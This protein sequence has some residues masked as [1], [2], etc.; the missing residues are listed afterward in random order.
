MK[1][2]ILD[3]GTFGPGIDINIYRNLGEL[4][5]Y[6]TTDPSEIN[7]RIKYSDVVIV[8]KVKLNESNLYGCDT[9]KLICVMATGYDNIDVDFC[10]SKGIAV[11]NVVGY[12]TQSVAQLTIAMALHLITHIPEYTLSVKSGRY[13]RGTNANILSPVYHE[14]YG[15]TW[16]IVGY[17]N[18][19]RQV[20]SVARAM[21]CKI[22]VNKRE[23]VL[24]VDC[25]DIDTLCEQSDIISI[26][27]PLNNSTRNL[28][29]AERVAKMK[30]TAIV[31]N[32]ARGAVVDEYAL[33]KA[34][35]EGKLGGIGIDV[36]TQEPFDIQHPYNSLSAYDNV[37]LTPH[38]AWGAIEARIRCCEEVY[39]NIEAFMAGDR[40]QRID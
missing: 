10:R 29:T 8:N 19:G 4:E 25:V 18:I 31:I 28:I 16:G 21:G 32:V 5:V 22:I 35:K 15:K 37:C 23:P 13:S 40:R 36:Y 12:S 6:Q 14:I 38:M 33:A 30:K 27:T 11:C 24:E 26:H 2:T 39:K 9:L 1:I 20:A 7:K 3:C 34:V 17:G